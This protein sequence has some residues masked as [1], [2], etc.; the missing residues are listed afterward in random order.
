MSRPS[1]RDQIITQLKLRGAQHAAELAEEL[2]VSPMAIR[3]H[4]Q[5]LKG[6]GWVRYQED[7][8]PLGRPVK[9]WSLTEQSHSRFPD[10]HSDL[11]LDLLWSA[12][13]VFGEEGLHRMIADRQQRQVQSYRQ[14]L[15]EAG[16]AKDWQSTTVAIAHFRNQEGYMA[17]VLPDSDE[18]L[19]LVE[20]HCPIHVAAQGCQGLCH[21]ELEVF[22]SLLGPEVTVERVEH[23]MQGD[24]RCA[25]RV[26]KRPHCPSGVTPQDEA[27]A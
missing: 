9:L 17:E 14:Q 24:R 5:V 3:Q 4:L 11:T 12:A 6:E 23:I 20:N 8:R 2:G 10:S 13:R 15:A 26:T 16:A 1:V 27:S 25:Y 19:L 7:H 21:A 18:S 22:Q